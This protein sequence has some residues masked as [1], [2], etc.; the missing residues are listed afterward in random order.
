[1]PRG[2]RRLSPSITVDEA[3]G[4]IVSFESLLRYSESPFAAQNLSVVTKLR[5]ALPGDMVGELDRLR[6]HVAVLEPVHQSK[7]PLL[8]KLL[9]A[10]LDETHLKVTY[11]SATSSVSERTVFPFGVYAAQGFWYCACY[12]YKRKRNISFRADRFLSVKRVGGLDPPVHVPLED[13]TEALEKGSERIAVRAY[14]T[15]QGAKSFELASLID[16]MAV[17][18]KMTDRGGVMETEI[19]RSDIDYWAARLLSLGGNLKVLSPPELVDAM[20]NKAR[21]VAALYR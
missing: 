5:A 18:R 21:E 17:E 20:L 11:D 12:D 3:L 10:A 6:R 7:A 9:G 13:W 4:M 19:L 14:V 2:G 1:M 8:G 16:R 15:E